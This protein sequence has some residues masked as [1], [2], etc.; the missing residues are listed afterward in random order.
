MKKIIPASQEIDKDNFLFY[1]KFDAEN[2]FKI[3]ASLS[4][5]EVYQVKWE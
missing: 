4:K 2:L 5:Q 3:F 1:K